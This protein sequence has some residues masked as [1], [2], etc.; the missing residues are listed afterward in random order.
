MVCPIFGCYFWTGF[1]NN[2]AQKETVSMMMN[3]G[4]VFMEQSN[5]AAAN[6]T[7]ECIPEA[8]VTTRYC[9]KDLGLN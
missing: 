3:A 5:D 1:N 4:E 7:N 6:D 8:Q 9:L 2:I